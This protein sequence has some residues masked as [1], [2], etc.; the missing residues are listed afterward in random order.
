MHLSLTVY[1]TI[2]SKIS[3]IRQK[4]KKNSP[5]SKKSIRQVNDT[6]LDACMKFKNHP[7]KSVGENIFYIHY[8]LYHYFKIS[9][10]RQKFKN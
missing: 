2:I 5:I 1:Y 3:K 4:K 9:K 10:I 7:I 6:I 8:A